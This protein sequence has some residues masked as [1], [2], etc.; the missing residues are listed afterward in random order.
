MAAKRTL[1]WGRSLRYEFAAGLVAGLVAVATA[2]LLRRAIAAPLFAEVVTD[3]APAVLNPRGF[4]TLLSEFGSDGKPLLFLSVLLVQAIG[5]AVLGV[6]S[7]RLYGHFRSM[8]ADDAPLALRYRLAFWAFVGL[9]V[10]LATSL[11]AAILTWTTPAIVPVRAGWAELVLTLLASSTAFVVVAVVL[12]PGQSGW[13]RGPESVA[14]RRRRD[15]ILDPSR[16]RILRLSGGALLGLG[17]AV[18][19]GRD[20]W[21]RRGGGAQRTVRS[22]PTPEVTANEDFYIISKN[23]FDPRVPIN[24]WALSVLGGD[25]PDFQ[26]RYEALLERPSR[27]LAITMQCISNEVGG[28]LM[29]NA[30]W[31]GFPLRELLEEVGV[32]DGTQ[33][34][35]FRSW[36]GYTESLPL[37]FAMRESTML[38][39]HMN[40][41]P[42]ADSHGF[43][44]RLLAPGKYGIKH[45]KWITEIAFLETEIFGFWQQRGWTQDGTMKTS[46]RIDQPFPGQTLVPG[47]VQIQGVAFSGDRG[48][49]QVEV[50]SDRGESWQ[51]A[52]LRPPFRH[53]AGCC[54]VWTRT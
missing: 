7:V 26:L 27:E 11:V 51:E 50:S 1:N 8:H 49:A 30:V 46:S 48:I 14:R 21:E 40:G 16:R 18:I 17:S 52:A 25:Q 35:A 44:L 45:P 12:A 34:I 5:F 29:G 47:Q 41:L 28:D 33:F 42:L 19:L 2:L 32:P 54:G 39:T 23:L 38:A 53:S 31:T 3:A 4:A 9:S 37:A 22:G 36:D 20:V 10:V 43:P 13:L 6:L 15:G 24:Q